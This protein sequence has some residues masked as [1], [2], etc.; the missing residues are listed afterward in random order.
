[1][2]RRKPK[3]LDEVDEFKKFVAAMGGEVFAPTNQYEVV[4][5][6]GNGVTSIIYRKENGNR[7]FTGDARAVWDAWKAGK[8]FRL[9]VATTRRHGAVLAP[10]DRAIIERDGERCFYCDGTFSD[11]RPRSR[12]HLVSATHGGPNH[13]ANLFHACQQCNREAGHLS[14]PE[15]IRLRDLKRRTA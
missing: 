4:R 9:T 3:L 2:A 5:F 14:A 1:M 10:L 15:K 12:E 8:T 7:T 11:E 6:R 13:I